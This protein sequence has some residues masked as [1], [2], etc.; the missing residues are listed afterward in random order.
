MDPSAAPANTCTAAV[1]N[2]G[3]TV[4]TVDLCARA[5]ND[6]LTNFDEDSVDT[7]SVD[8]TAV[9][10]PVANKMVAFAFTLTYGTGAD[11]NV[12][13]EDIA[14][15][16]INAEN[17]SLVNVG[18]GT[19][20][21]DGSFNAVAVDTSL[22]PASVEAGSGVLDRLGLEA[23]GPGYVVI[24]LTLSMNVHVDTS[25]NSAWTPDATGSAVMAV[26]GPCATDADGDGRPDTVD[27][28][29]AVSNAGQENL[30]G[31]ALGDL[32][33]ADDD[34]DLVADVDEGP[35]SSDPVDITPPFSR[36]E[37]IDGVFAGVDDDGDTLIDEAL[38]PSAANFDCDGDGYTGA[39]EGGTPL[40]GNGA[41]DDDKVGVALGPDD[42]VI[43]D[44]CPGGPA[45][46][47]SFSEAQFNIGGN[48]QDPCGLASWPSDFIT[49]G[50]PPSTNK[51][52]VLDLTS[53]IAP[54]EL[55]RLNTA[56]GQPTF[57]KRWDLSPGRGVFTTMINVTDLTSLI[58]GMSGFPPMLAGVRAFNGP[59][60][61]WPP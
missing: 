16:L 26:N 17:S 27:N 52:N 23:V 22:S 60:C 46:V 19:P 25:G 45:Q 58:A 47:G 51:I 2:G 14:F 57:D 50:V 42:G 8:I 54:V 11:V 48:D 4:G 41:N 3:C 7:L 37:R 24:P 30:D 35:C 15:L 21:S 56:P 28:C 13:T 20:D 1:S 5:D 44:D 53:F 61:P 9:N 6:G 36:P 33:D 18:D 40:C 31:D 29:P 55:K 39:A 12:A 49:G 59:T 43:D 38:P 34:N 10:I 32:C